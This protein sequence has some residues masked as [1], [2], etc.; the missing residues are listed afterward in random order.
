MANNIAEL[1]YTPIW[2]EETEKKLADKVV[3]WLKNSRLRVFKFKLKELYDKVQVACESGL[4]KQNNKRGR[5]RKLSDRVMPCAGGGDGG[6]N[7]NF[8]N[9]TSDS[10]E[11]IEVPFDTL[12]LMDSALHLFDGGGLK[13]L[14]GKDKNLLK[15]LRRLN[16]LLPPKYQLEFCIG[17]VVARRRAMTRN[18]VRNFR[19]EAMSV[20]RDAFTTRSR[21]LEFL[22][23]RCQSRMFHVVTTDGKGAD[24]LTPGDLESV[25]TGITYDSPIGSISSAHVLL[26]TAKRQRIPFLLRAVSEETHQREAVFG[27]AFKEA[28]HIVRAWEKVRLM[29]PLPRHVLGIIHAY[30]NPLVNIA[31]QVFEDTRWVIGFGDIDKNHC[32]CDVERCTKLLRL[33]NDPQT[34]VGYISRLLGEFMV[35]ETDLPLLLETVFRIVGHDLARCATAIDLLVSNLGVWALPTLWKIICEKLDADSAQRISG[36]VVFRLLID[37]GNAID[38]TW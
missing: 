31:E 23:S 5:K 34:T 29:T 20:S 4:T 12:D 19:K 33:A 10:E 21:V 1:A 14:L 7:R 36:K 18:D 22:S 35:T 11:E 27:H 8:A 24:H 15:R 6:E 26:A 28:E 9:I 25:S 3:A 13:R 16:T 2:T 17:T 37:Y 38:C 32:I 30:C